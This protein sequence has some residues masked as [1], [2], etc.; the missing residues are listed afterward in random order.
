MADQ[1]ETAGAR[2]AVIDLAARVVH[3]VVSKE[4]GLPPGCEPAVTD[5]V[6]ARELA[7]RGLLV[8]VELWDERA[9]EATPMLRHAAALA[10]RSGKKRTAE[11][12]TA[13]ATLPPAEWPPAPAYKGPVVPATEHVQLGARL[14]AARLNA[15]DAERIANDLRAERDLLLW[16]HAEAVHFGQGWHAQWLAAREAAGFA[17]RRMTEFAD[18]R[19]QLQAHVDRVRFEIENATLPVGA[20][21]QMSDAVN[22]AHPVS[23]EDKDIDVPHTELRARR[24]MDLVYDWLRTIRAIPATL[25]DDQPAEPTPPSA[26]DSGEHMMADGTRFKVWHCPAHSTGSVKWFGPTAHCMEDGCDH[27]SEEVPGG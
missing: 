11:W 4:L 15:A 17:T 18:A 27:H 5:V 14:D 22:L 9:R 1:T 12:L 25:Q 2:D 16:L 23:E 6:A 24:A 26:V 20:L 10:A 19:D 13:C 7:R 21:Q 8:P 3:E